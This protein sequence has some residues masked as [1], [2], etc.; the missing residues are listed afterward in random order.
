[1]AV[2]KCIKLFFYL[3]LMTRRVLGSMQL[4]DQSVWPS[5]LQMEMEKRPKLA[6]TKLMSVPCSHLISRVVPSQ[7]YFVLFSSSP[8]IVKIC[9]H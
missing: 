1:M 3:A 2:S 6:L 9:K 8:E 5:L 7:P 4:T